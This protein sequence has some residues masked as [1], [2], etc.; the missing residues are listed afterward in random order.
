MLGCGTK[1]KLVRSIGQVGGGV[2][3]LTRNRARRD[4]VTRCIVQPY[5][6]AAVALA[7]SPNLQ[8]GRV[9]LLLGSP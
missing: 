7:A 1:Q 9:T 6:S 8:E 4:E 3:E 5:K 2:E